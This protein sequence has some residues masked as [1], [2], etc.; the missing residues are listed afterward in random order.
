MRQNISKVLT[1]FQAGQPATGDSKGTCSTDGQTVWSYRMPIAW[2]EPDGSITIVAREKGPS[3][4]TKS[5]IDA[6]RLRLEHGLSASGARAVSGEAFDDLLWSITEHDVREIRVR[7]ALAC[8]RL[9]DD[10]AARDRDLL[11]DAVEE[12]WVE[13]LSAREAAEKAEQDAADA[14]S[15]LEEVLQGEELE[16]VSAERDE[17]SKVAD[18]FRAELAAMTL[19][20]LTAEQKPVNVPCSRCERVL[21]I[22]TE[23]RPAKGKKGKKS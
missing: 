12:M 19:R 10:V 15:R 23:D 7:S 11:L 13:Y 5:Q 17:L 20:A 6:C 9:T 21:R 4:T 2:R 22:L 1:A 16:K 18:E 3:R 14:E 8:S